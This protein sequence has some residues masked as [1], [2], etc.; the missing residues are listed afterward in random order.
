MADENNVN[1][2]TVV[3]VAAKSLRNADFVVFNP[4]DVSDPYCVCE[5]PDKPQHKIRTRTIDNNLDPVWNHEE[6]L[7]GW[8]PG[9]PLLFTVYDKDFGKRDEKLGWVKL[10]SSQ[11]QKG[12]EGDVDLHDC[13]GHR[14][15]LSLRICF[16]KPMWSRQSVQQAAMAASSFTETEVTNLKARKRNMRLGIANAGSGPTR[17]QFRDFL[18]TER[19]RTK[20]CS[21]MPFTLLIA[22]S[23]S[24]VA[25]QHGHVQSVN[26]LRNGVFRVLEGIAV[27]HVSSPFSL[28]NVSS[29]EEMWAWIG[30]GLIPELGG[31]TLRPGFVLSFNKVVGQVELVQ[32]RQVSEDCTS[33]GNE[34]QAYL[35]LPCRADA[36]D[37]ESY[38][39]PPDPNTNFT[40]DPAFVSGGDLGDSILVDED[41]FYAFLD[42]VPHYRGVNRA[43]FLEQHSWVDQKTKW[44]EIRLALFNGEIKAFTFVSIRFA[45][46]EGGLIDK[47]IKADPMHIPEWYVDTIIIDAAWLALILILFLVTVQEVIDSEDHVNPLHRCCLSVWMF[48]D[49]VGVFCGGGVLGLFMLLRGYLNSLNQRLVVLG[50]VDALEVPTMSFTVEQIARSDAQWRDY[51]TMLAQVLSELGLATEMKAYHRI[52][53][54]WFVFWVLIRFFRGCIGQPYFAT[55]LCTIAE[56]APDVS[57][58]GIILLITFENFALSGCIFFGS[59]LKEWSSINAAHRSS[60]AMISGMGDFASM[61]ERFPVSASIWL[62]FFALTILF[63]ASNMIFAIMIDHFAEVKQEV[64]QAYTN[65]L[66]QS[67]MYVEDILW[68]AAYKGRRLSERIRQKLPEKLVIIWPYFDEEPARA[69]VPY[70]VIIEALKP[71]AVDESADP[72]AVIRVVSNLS[73]DAENSPRKI[74]IPAWVRAQPSWAPIQRDV[75]LACGCDGSTA[76]LLL[77]RCEKMGKNQRPKDFPTDL[78]YHEV[79]GHLNNIFDRLSVTDEDLRTWLIERT[80]D[81][82]Q[83][84]PRQRKL[85]AL[86][87]E[88]IMPKPA[89]DQ[90]MLSP[91]ALTCGDENRET[92]R[93]SAYPALE[94]PKSYKPD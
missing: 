72:E 67:I 47:T 61:Y 80:V 12:F 74:E 88:K 87:V 57:H 89:P 16:G 55:I 75:L 40:K 70:E 52:G 93:A 69:P 6:F 14:S 49:W 17:Q 66:T 1:L 9:D 54:F 35:Q 65:F 92:M 8:E 53:T 22:A 13:K 48:M 85:E 4:L 38:G 71:A 18:R 19:D 50:A 81:W 29:V 62:F 2:L 83:L 23:F 76:E 41:H 33:I 60:L 45:F 94:A 37:V 78:V 91:P 64:G 10:M 58:L 3:I 34:L 59:C 30:D 43:K 21:T 7:H 32:Q 25:W 84:Q 5:I 28:K 20:Y 15:K 31:D 68:N 51:E 86:A 77:K 79:K 39:P 63:V 11:F 36:L 44:V 46:S 90:P 24:L 27:D 42:V 56:A 82:Q 73:A 26:L